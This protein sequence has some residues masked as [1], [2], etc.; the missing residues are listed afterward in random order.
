VFSYHK[1]FLCECVAVRTLYGSVI[2]TS[3]FLL[4]LQRK[5]AD[6]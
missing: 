3:K 6:E 2:V 4:P 1:A 5:W